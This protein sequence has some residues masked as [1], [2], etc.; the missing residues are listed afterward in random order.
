MLPAG[1]EIVWA[2]QPG[3]QTIF[4]TCPHFEVLYEGTR[5][6]G[7]TDALLMDFAQHVGRGYGR[8]WRGV[9]FRQTY[10]QLGDVIAK[11]RKWFHRAFPQARFNASDHTWTW[12]DGEQLLLR[13]MKRPDDYWNYHGHEYPWIG[14]EELTTWSDLK[15]YDLMKSC[16]RSSDPRVPRKYRSTANPWGRGHNQ[17][18]AR[19]IDPAPP[20][21]P[22]T[23]DDGLKVV[24]I[25]GHWSENRILLAAD[26]EYPKRIAAA[27]SNPEQAKAWLQGSWDIVAGGM[28]DDLWGPKLILPRFPVPAGWRM[29]RAFDWGSTR[30]FSYGLWAESD[31]TPIELPGRTVH[32]ARGT[33]VRVAEWY[34]WDGKNPNT[35]LRMTDPDIG[36]G[37]VERES[38]WGYRE[39]IEPGPADAAIFTAAADG[40]SIAGAL[41]AA[42]AEFTPSAKGARAPGWQA[43]RNMMQAGL[44]APREEPGL[45]V[46]EDCRQWLRTV[47]VMPRSEKDPDD[48]DTDAEDHAADETRYKITTKRIERVARTFDHMV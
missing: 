27:A 37:I 28:F 46:V 43:M 31:G 23:N 5:G 13:H 33:L 45:F 36:R 18:K 40:K 2:P 29:D 47:P 22:W 12:P 15:C 42:G 19:F 24:R 26:P 14:W 35:G 17:V 11:S 20:G 4:L 1:T 39:R 25:R 6:P 38:R 30:P 8:S 10:K 7:K 32:L 16:C 41:A 9:L 21:V 44:E 3:S 34:G 48:V